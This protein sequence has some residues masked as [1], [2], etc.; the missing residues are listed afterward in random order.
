MTDNH[1]PNSDSPEDLSLDALL[2]E[3]KQQIDSAPGE[4][5][6]TGDEPSVSSQPQRS[7]AEPMPLV[8]QDEDFTPDFGDAFDSYGEYEEP[9]PTDEGEYYDEELPEND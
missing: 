1:Y 5:L 8:S 7:V 3:A 4:M 9:N 6:Q 2:A